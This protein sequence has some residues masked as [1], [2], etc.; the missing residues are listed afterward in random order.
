MYRAETA[1]ADL[2]TRRVGLDGHTDE[3]SR[4]ARNMLGSIRLDALKAVMLRHSPDPTNHMTDVWHYFTIKSASSA[5]EAS[6][7]L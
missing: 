3:P 4:M 7:V 5:S 1:K 6:S 2:A